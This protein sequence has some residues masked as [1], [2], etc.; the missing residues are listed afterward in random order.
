MWICK[1]KK[2]E[3]DYLQIHFDVYLM[4]T[5]QKKQIWCLASP[6]SVI[7]VKIGLWI[8]WQRWGLGLRQEKTEKVVECSKNIWSDHSTGK[9]V[10]SFQNNR[11]SPCCQTHDR[12]MEITTWAQETLLKPVCWQ[13][14]TFCLSFLHH[15]SFFGLNISTAT[16]FLSWLSL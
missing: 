6:A 2:F 9:Q 15:P 8:S 12:M 5:V 16:Y 4:R 14:I 11:G 7:F 13:V 1:K 10:Q 3:I